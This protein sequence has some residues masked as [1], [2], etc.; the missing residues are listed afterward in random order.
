MDWPPPRDRQQASQ[1]A[2]PCGNLPRSDDPTVLQAGE[3][4][5]VEF[6]ETIYHP[7]WYRISWSFGD[8]EGFTENILADC[9]PHNGRSDSEYAWEIV[10]PDAPC[11]TCTLQVVQVMTD[12]GTGFDSP[13]GWMEY[14]ACADVVVTGSGGGAGP[15]MWAGADASC[16]DGPKGGE[17]GEPSRGGGFGCTAGP[18]AAAPALVLLLLALALA[19]AEPHRPAGG[20]LPGRLRRGGAPGAAA[21]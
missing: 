12:K 3:T 1:K 16:E 15:E 10:V 20:A 5:T 18:G 13:T 21:K 9:I 2:E 4:I 11:E 7:G 17:A 8:D 19:L 6:R 14:Y